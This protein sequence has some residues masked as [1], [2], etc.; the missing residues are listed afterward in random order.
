MVRKSFRECFLMTSQCPDCGALLDDGY[1]CRDAFDQM[2]YWE[3]DFP[4][5]G[6][7]HHLTVLAYHLQHPW[8]YSVE[9]LAE[10]K[11]LLI[12]F[13]RE[14]NSPQDVRRQNQMAYDSGHRTFHIKATA[15]SYGWY[16]PPVKWSMTAPDVVA[17][18]I[19]N[20][21][22]SVTAWAGSIFDALEASGQLYSPS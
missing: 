3:A 9:G 16:D 11:R 5:L 12:A 8:L 2:L 6:I 13:L 14:G 1:T 18:G 10:A 20:Y 22:E 7:V 17:A 21:V 4:E 15:E 19:D